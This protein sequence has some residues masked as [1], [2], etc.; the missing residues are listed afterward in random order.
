MAAADATCYVVKNQAYRLTA[1]ILSISTS[2]AITG[3]LTGLSGSISKDGAAFVATANAPIEIGTSGV[4]T[5]DLTAAELNFSSCFLT[6]SATNTNAKFSYTLLLT[7]GV[8]QVQSGLATSS[9][10]SAGITTITTAISASQ[11]A[12]IVAIPSSSE[13][14]SAVWSALESGSVP[15]RPATQGGLLATIYRYLVNKNQVEKSTQVQ[16]LFG[17]DNSTVL[18]SGAITVNADL[19]VKGKLS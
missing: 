7:G 11:T 6:L 17:D 9:A 5:I 16:T 2:N 10:L 4:I 18:L 8:A 14:A 3:G 15:G 1:V 12:I 13:A 19:T